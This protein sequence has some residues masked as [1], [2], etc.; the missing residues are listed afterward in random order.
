VPTPSEIASLFMS[1]S[2]RAYDEGD[3]RL[4]KYA[5]LAKAAA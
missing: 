5:K 2:D 4:L 1:G 3:V